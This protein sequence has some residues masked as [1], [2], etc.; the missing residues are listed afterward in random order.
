MFSL[1]L[2]FSAP[3]LLH[4]KHVPL[5]LDVFLKMAQEGRGEGGRKGGRGLAISFCLF[6]LH[7]IKFNT[8]KLCPRQPPP[9]TPPPTPPAPP[10]PALQWKSKFSAD[11]EIPTAVEWRGGG[12][13]RGG[14]GGA[15]SGG[16]DYCTVKFQE[17]FSW[18][19][20][21]PTRT[22]N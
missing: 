22:I 4:R 11:I 3:F 5:P 6:F 7:R 15:G 8:F 13:D 12:C 17:A 1:N 16:E 2:L 9:P 18:L 14:G 19:A 10:P 21:C 20:G